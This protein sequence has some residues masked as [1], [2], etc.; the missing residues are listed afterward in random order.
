M[1]Y[2]VRPSLNLVLIKKK[3]PHISCNGIYSEKRDG[4]GQTNTHEEGQKQ[5]G[6]ENIL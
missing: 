6:E 3:H 5:S 4:D 1:L 2:G